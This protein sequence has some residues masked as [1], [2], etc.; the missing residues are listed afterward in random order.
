VFGEKDYQQLQVIRR[1]GRALDMPV[2]SVGA[3]TARAEDGLA[4][5][6]RTAYRPPEERQTAARLNQ[7]LREAIATLRAG[8]R[9]D[10]AEAAAVEAL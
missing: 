9:L 6:S 10:A 1:L 7:A 8:G 5:S 4:L 2:E 3:P